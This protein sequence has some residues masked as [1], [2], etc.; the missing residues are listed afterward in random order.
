M[1]RLGRHALAIARATHLF[2]VLVVSLSAGGFAILAMAEEPAVA[3]ARVLAVV[4]GMFLLQVTIGCTN[5][6][7]D[8]HDDATGKPWRPIPSGDLSPRLV[9]WLAVVAGTGGLLVTA[10]LG[11]A[12]LAV[13]ALGLSIGLLY[14]VW[15]KRTRLSW[16]PYVAALPLVPIWAFVAVGRDATQ[17]LLLYPLGLT[18]MIGVHIANTLPDLEVDAETGVRGL[19]HRL[20][21]RGA[22]V[23]CVGAMAATPGLMLAASAFAPMGLATFVPAAVLYLLLVAVG[24]IVSERATAGSRWLFHLY[25]PAVALLGTAWVASIAVQ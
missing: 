7:V 13:A 16:L 22:L 21:R 24:A 6:Y 14:N 9:V 11:A 2:A 3:D 23:V 19:P 15:L 20:G 8:R 12:A 25:A 18:A 4:V 17:L 5:E 1:K 10:T